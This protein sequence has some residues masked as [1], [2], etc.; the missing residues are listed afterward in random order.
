MRRQIDAYLTAVQMD[1]ERRHLFVEGYRNRNF[2]TWLCGNEIHSNVS[3][4]PIDAIDFSE[5][6]D[7]GNR[8]RLVEIARTIEGQTDAIMFFADADYDILLKRKL[9]SNV[10]Y[11]DRRDIEGYIFSERSLEKIFVLSL[12]TEK[13]S[14]N[15]FKLIVSICKRIASIRIYSE[16]TSSRIAFKSTSLKRYITKDSMFLFNLEGYTRALLQNSNI[17]LSRL[18]SVLLGAK[19]IEE[20]LDDLDHYEYIHGKDVI[21][22]FERLLHIFGVK[23][24]E[25]ERLLWAT[26]D[27]PECCLHPRLKETL[28]YMKKII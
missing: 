27:R 2:L 3:V 23:D 10:F 18:E 13:S 8:G 28:K 24:G 9:L 20:R 21:S 19:S 22:V 12:N 4:L 26:V 15:F 25:A 7:G 11:T 5:A 6:V 17:S 14:T 16:E 1:P